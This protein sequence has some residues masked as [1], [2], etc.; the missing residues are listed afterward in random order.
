M[1]TIS[2]FL[3][4]AAPIALQ[5]WHGKASL[6]N[7]KQPLHSFA[8]TLLT[9]SHEALSIPYLLYTA[10]LLAPLLALGSNCLAC[11]HLGV[12]AAVYSILWCPTTCR[13][14]CVSHAAFKLLI[15]YLLVSSIVA[16]TVTPSPTASPS[17]LCAAGWSYYSDSDGSEGQASCLKVTGT[18][19]FGWWTAMTS[20]PMNSH[21]LTMAGASVN[22]GL[23]AYSRT[24][25]SSAASVFFWVGAS[26]SSTATSLNRGWAWIDGT[27]ASN[28][29]CG[30]AG[31]QGCGLWIVW[32]TLADEPKCVGVITP[33]CLSVDP[34]QTKSYYFFDRSVH[35][36]AWRSRKRVAQAT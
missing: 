17:T 5:R 10:V 27:S 26:Q 19:T 18:S 11:D 23:H 32:P 1:I 2:H 29:N 24:L 7:I 20:C 3:R 22:G 30:A 21:L 6:P 8:L 4:G 33:V 9:L 35:Q 25:T 28:M 12:A 16:Q 14:L 13:L 36:T 15:A 31:E 34:H